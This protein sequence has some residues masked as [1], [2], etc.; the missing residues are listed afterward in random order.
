MATFRAA[1]DLKSGKK[2]G[3]GS[4]ARHARYLLRK[5]STDENNKKH[6]RFTEEIAGNL[7]ELVLITKDVMKTKYRFLP[8]TV[9]FTQEESD[10]L[11]NDHIQQIGIE[12]A[13]HL[14]SPLGLERVPFSIQKH[15]SKET[16]RV[17]L[18]VTLARYDLQ[19][20]KTFQPYVETREPRQTRAEFGDGKRLQVFQDL[21]TISFKLDDPRNPLRIR[22]IRR[23]SNLPK[24]KKE[25]IAEINNQIEACVKSG[26][27]KTRDD[28]VSLLHTMDVS[29]PRAG[30]KYITVKTKGMKQGVRLKGAAFTASFSGFIEPTK[31]KKSDEERLTELQNQLD[32]IDKYR[33]PLFEKHFRQPENEESPPKLDKPAKYVASK[34]IELPGMNAT[35]P[36]GP[37]RSKKPE[38]AHDGRTTRQA[39]YKHSQCIDP[40]GVKAAHGIRIVDLCAFDCEL[41]RWS[42]QSVHEIYVTDLGNC[43]TNHGIESEWKLTAALAAT[44][45]RE[46]VS[47]TCSDITTAWIAIKHHRNFGIETSSVVVGGSGDVGR[48]KIELS[49]QKLN[50]LLEQDD[51]QRNRNIESESLYDDGEKGG[52]TH[53]GNEADTAREPRI[54]ELNA[55]IA[56]ECEKL[57]ENQQG[58]RTRDKELSGRVMASVELRAVIENLM[59]DGVQIDM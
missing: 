36:A 22:W 43:I 51:E 57:H 8:A 42:Y 10:R 40:G 20:G 6:P 52:C 15:T 30:Q 13:Q 9:G 2:S 25:L 47:I 35:Y 33:R 19:I 50:K 28:I 58:N 32:D 39:E 29:T 31:P 38:T 5:Y 21:Q 18:H 41:Q 16:G 54:R 24:D 1:G 55:R 46:N 37:R 48:R 7:D 49:E 44:K 17:D 23:Q 45:G 56:F 59:D 12:F 14:A 26:T 11:T 53:P 34:S 27:V 4:A 3:V